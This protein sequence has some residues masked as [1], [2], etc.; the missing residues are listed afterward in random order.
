MIEAVP[1]R[2]RLFSL[3]DSTWLSPYATTNDTTHTTKDI[4]DEQ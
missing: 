1:E 3:L 2:G 4:H